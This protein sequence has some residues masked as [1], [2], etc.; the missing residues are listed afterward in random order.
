ML[1]NHTGHYFFCRDFT[2]LCLFEGRGFQVRENDIY[3]KFGQFMNSDKFFFDKPTYIV[4]HREV[5]L[6]KILF[7][8][9]HIFRRS[10]HEK[11][12]EKKSQEGEEVNQ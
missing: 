3:L 9:I 6:P 10:L 5:T 11:N 2:Y 12:Q 7:R 1:G 4:V 8:T